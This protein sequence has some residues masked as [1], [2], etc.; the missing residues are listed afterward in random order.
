MIFGTGA[1]ASYFRSRFA[2]AIDLRGHPL[3]AIGEVYDDVID[4]VLGLGGMAD[5]TDVFQLTMVRVQLRRGAAK[6]TA[7]LLYYIFRHSNSGVRGYSQVFEFLLF[8]GFLFCG[9]QP[10]TLRGLADFLLQL[11]F[12]RAS[13]LVLILPGIPESRGA[14]MR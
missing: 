7:D 10:Q 5:Q 13:Y 3:A 12:H 2:I 14:S 9:T 8:G 1:G 4:I 11:G 6:F